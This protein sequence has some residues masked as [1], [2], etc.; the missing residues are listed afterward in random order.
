MNDKR[1][2]L[3]R[4]K[5]AHILLMYPPDADETTKELIKLRADSIYQ[6][7]VRGENFSELAKKY[8]DDKGSAI[9]GGELPWLS[10]FRLVLLL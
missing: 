4:F 5:V 8:S 2:A 9:N 7:L 3:Y 1:P 10:P 6:N